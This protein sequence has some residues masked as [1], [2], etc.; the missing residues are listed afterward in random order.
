[1]SKSSGKYQAGSSLRRMTTVSLLMALIV[2][3]A[4]LGSFIK[5][6]PVPIS[7][8]LCPIIIGAAL[9]GPAIGALL[10]GVYGVVVFITGLMGW[11]GGFVMLLTETRPLMCAALCIGKT[12]A[13]GCLAGVV[14]RAVSLLRK[15]TEGNSKL[16]VI[17]AGI[18]CPV[19]NTGIFI[20]W[21]LIFW[22]AVL[23]SMAGGS[24][25]LLFAMTTFVGA[26]FAVELVI[27]MVLASAVTLIIGYAAG[28][29]R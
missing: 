8:T 12:A 18:V 27:N 20:S 22:K 21:M 23:E 19:V 11:D 26:N 2:V 16:A 28:R 3:L 5:I 1:M 14:Y 9:Y 17:I 10:G 29:R 7:L 6:G 15:K 25:V 4:C 13:A 24:D